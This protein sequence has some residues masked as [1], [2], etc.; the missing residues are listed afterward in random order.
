MKFDDDQKQEWEE[1]EFDI[2]GAD[3][4]ED[5]SVGDQVE[6]AVQKLVRDTMGEIPA[7]AYAKEE[8]DEEEQDEDGDYDGD[9]YDDE[10]DEDDDEDEG[11]R[12]KGGK[13]KLM[14]FGI[15]AAVA[16]VLLAGF[17]GY[18]AFYFTSHFFDGTV[19]NGMDSS[20]MT[21]EQVEK[22]I[23]ESAQNY[24]LD[25]YFRNGDQQ[26]QGN[27]I[28]YRYQPDGSVQDLLKKQNVFAW[29]MENSRNKEHQINVTMQYDEAKLEEQV[30][31]FQQLQADQMQAPTNA[32]IQYQSDGFVVTEENQGT[33]LDVD[34]AKAVI[35]DAVAKGVTELDMD[36]AGVYSEPEI[37][38][39]DSNLEE[40]AAQLNDLVS[41][42]ITYQLPDGQTQVLD[43]NTMK[44]WLSVDENGSYSKND[45]VWNQKLNEYVAS[46]AEAVDTYG[47]A[48]TFPATGIDEGVKVTQSNYGWKIDQEQEAAQLAKDIEEHLTTT[49]EPV[50]ASREFASDNNGFGN[51]YVEIDVSR[52]H[53]WFYKD[54]SLIVD[55]SCVTGKMVK[56]RYTPAGIF[57]LVSKTSPKTLRGPKQADGSYEWESDVTYWMPFNGGI[58]LHDATW[59]SSFGG[60][61]YINSGSHG[62]INLPLSV[63]KKI[64]NNIEVGTP[65][66]VYYSE[67]YSV[68]DDSAERAAQNL[69]ESA[70]VTETTP[71]ATS[72]PTATATPTATPTPTATAAPTETP[73]AT[74]VPTETP[75][76]PE[77]TP[78]E[79][80]ATPE[81]TPTE[82]PATPEPTPT[83]VP[84]TP[85]A[86][87]PE[88]TQVPEATSAPEVTQAP[89]VPQQ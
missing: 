13:K 60:T 11:P 87:P 48:Q 68:R 40:Q 69:P 51:T 81:P 10:F 4:E 65:I 54:G 43:G 71:T 18:R 53:V 2:P 16:V 26:I 88:A 5:S 44:D 17:Y 30:S 63:A 37:T 9:E 38:A 14:I 85:E 86:T 80:P 34:Q 52:Q 1:L 39:A 89:E 21:A 75:A 73:T 45:E 72:T 20:G 78:T 22:V 23:E 35:A 12:R 33:Q 57:Q 49:R 64:Y 74:P 62:C 66:I 36:E 79:A 50:Y 32:Q 7:H 70:A 15:V 19:I 6:E 83:E 84:A 56:S 42:S 47:E 41:A 24:T 8:E 46:L 59:R 67:K 61:R 82:A 31:Q 77:P 55:S 29:L 27:T 58:G 3:E 28:D 76:T 25:I